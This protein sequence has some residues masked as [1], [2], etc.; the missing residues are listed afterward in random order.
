MRAGTAEEEVRPSM[1]AT[2]CAIEW[3]EELRVCVED[4]SRMKEEEKL[5]FLSHRE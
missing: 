3:S 5:V 4:A 2:W 1:P